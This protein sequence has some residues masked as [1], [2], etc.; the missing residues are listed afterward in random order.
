MK[1][2]KWLWSWFGGPPAPAPEF[3]VQV[4]AKTVELCGFLPAAKTVGTIVGAL[5]GQG[6]AVATA[7]EV[8]S[9]I[10]QAVSKPKVALVGGSKPVVEINGEIIEIEGEYV[11]K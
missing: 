4:Q 11:G 2:L 10:C 6:P 7:L 5:S 3:V 8:A 9:T 1:W